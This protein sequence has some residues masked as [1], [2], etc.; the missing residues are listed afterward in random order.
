MRNVLKKL[1]V[2]VLVVST[3]NLGIA[4]GAHA[5]MVGTDQVNTS[6]SAADARTRLDA[7]LARAD[8]SSQLDTLGVNP[9]EAQSRVQAMTDDEVLAA[10]GKLDT[11]PA[12]G[13]GLGTLIGAAVFIFIVLLIT[14]ILGL[15]KV[16]PF[17]KPI[18]R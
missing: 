18:K 1:L 6:Q 15:T 9:V 11:L 10:A 14:D 8:V 2:Y 16:F 7:F 5:V 17:T 13:D 12:G 3:C 4:A